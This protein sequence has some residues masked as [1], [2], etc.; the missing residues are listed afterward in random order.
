MLFCVA[1]L[2]LLSS[3][4][5]QA[6]DAAQLFSKRVLPLLKSK[7]FECHSSK[8]EE[9]KGNL[10]LESLEEIL[11]GGDNGPAVVAGDVEM[12][13]LLKA[14]RYEEADYQMPPA[15]KLSDE[16]IKLLEEWVKKLGEEDK[17]RWPRP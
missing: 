3:A 9:V 5:A 2:A 17:K 13:F 6:E 12:S 1:H 11:K 8:A 15:G 14:V 16:N 7:C 4:S 10:K